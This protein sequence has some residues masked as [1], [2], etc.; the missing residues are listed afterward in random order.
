M[1]KECPRCGKNDMKDQIELNSISEEDAKTYICSACGSNETRMN[2]FKAKKLE[3][4]I[5]KEQFELQKKFRERL[6]LV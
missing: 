5:P 6:G 4:D 2:W 3:G 1:G